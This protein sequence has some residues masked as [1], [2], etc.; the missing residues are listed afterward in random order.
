MAACLAE[1]AQLRCKHERQLIAA[2]CAHRHRLR[3]AVRHLAV[4]LRQRRRTLAVAGSRLLRGRPGPADARRTGGLHLR[5]PVHR[6]HRACRPLSRQPHLR[7][8][9]PGRRAGQWRLRT[10]GYPVS[11]GGA[12]A[13]RHRTVPG[14][15]LP[16]GHEAGDRLDAQA[17]R[18]GTLLAG[19]HADSR[20]RHA[21]SAARW[22]PGHAVGVAAA[23][24]L[25]AGPAGR[26]HGAAA[27][28]RPA[29]A[30]F[31]RQGAAFR[32]PRRLGRKTLSR[33]GWRLLRSLLG[34]LRLLDADALP[35]HARSRTAHGFHRSGGV[36]FLRHHCAGTG[37]L[38]GGAVR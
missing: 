12:A 27:R 8:L 26:R 6:H 20:Y 31:R 3:P 32:R 16:A 4:V 33:R 23:G 29:P 11:A 13:L 2:P 7:R 35:G 17:H 25:A 30:A 14:R 37:G 24:H 1:G 15:H 36:A 38:R 22:N 19:G 9:L 5:H 34:T 21:A 28:R 18:S 10:G